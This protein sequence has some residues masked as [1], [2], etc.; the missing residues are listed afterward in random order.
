MKSKKK[1]NF[2]VDEYDGED[3]DKVEAQRLNNFFNGSLE[4]SFIFLI[5]QPIGKERIVNNVERKR[6][7]FELL[8]NMETYQ[9][10]RVTRNSVEIHNLVKLTTGVLH[11]QQ[12]VFFHEFENTMKSDQKPYG[13]LSKYRIFSE[14]RKL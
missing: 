2:I 6:N 3:L 7:R 13:L 10:N 5:V 8:R 14:K 4:Q 11:R 12:T 1:I 9:L